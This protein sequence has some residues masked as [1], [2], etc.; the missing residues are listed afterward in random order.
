MGEA[1]PIGFVYHIIG[2]DLNKQAQE[3]AERL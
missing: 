3:F 1:L 2:V